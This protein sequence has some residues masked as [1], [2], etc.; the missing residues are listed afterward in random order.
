[1]ENN[2]VFLTEEAMKLIAIMLIVGVVCA[3]GSKIIHLPDTVLFILAGVII[4]PELLNIV[5]FKDFPMANQFILTFGAAYILY[6][7]GREIKLSV[8]NRVKLSVGM[9]ATV[10]VV[11]SAFITGYFA[12]KVLHLDFIYALLLGSVI[13]ST[14]PSV[15]V[16][17]FKHMNISPKLKQTIISESAFNDAA[18]A[19]VTFVVVGIIG[20]GSFSPISSLLELL[21]T[22]GGGILTGVVFGYLATLIASEHKAGV[23]RGFPGEIAVASVMGAYVTAQHFGFSGFMAVFLVGIMCG[24]KSM[25]KLTIGKEGYDIHLSFKD[26]LIT[27]LRIMIFV[28]LGTQMDF[29]IIGEYW[30]GGIIVILLF[31]FIARPVS[32]IVSVIY[33]KKARWNYREILY[34]MWTRET[35]VIPAALAGM[36]VSMNIPNAK[37]VSALTSMAI[38][39]T[40]TFQASSAK[41]V[42]KLLKLDIN[43]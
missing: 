41:Y 14:D 39:I 42:A 36:L 10:G 27:I 26:V 3:K 9:L 30:K 40:L 34:L 25:F 29:T 7:G 23:L 28:L 15:L 31:I 43:E 11:V 12:S 32:V 4:G 38:I 2:I 19:I 22:A 24:N 16:P 17:L 33:D 20:G 18:G 35:G 6:D 5:D 37:I 8:L 21:K 1:M 13:A